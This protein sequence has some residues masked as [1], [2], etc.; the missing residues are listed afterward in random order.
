[1]P[2]DFDYALITTYLLKGIRVVQAN[3]DKLVALNFSDFNL[4]ERKAYNMLS[5]HKYLTRTKGNNLK[6]IPHPW[7]QNPMQSTL[8]NVMKI[9]H[10]VRHQEV[11][12]CV[13]LFLSF[14]HGGYLWL[15]HRITM[16]P[17]LIN[18]ITG[19]SMQG[20]NP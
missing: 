19:V 12:T 10:F 4:G 6:I 3:Q 2:Q 5:P 20:P 14:Y 11:N 15:N 8:L 1:V 9:S 17:T 16:D 13:K 18:R 7:T